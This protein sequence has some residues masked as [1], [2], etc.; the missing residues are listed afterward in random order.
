MEKQMDNQRSDCARQ[1]PL[2][3][4]DD[5]NMLE[6]LYILVRNKW[7]II[8]ATLLGIALGFGTAMMKGP[9]W[10]AEVIIAPKETE[11]PKAPNFSAFGALGGIVA[12]QLNMGANASLDKIELILDSREFNATFVERANLTPDIYKLQWPKVFRKYWDSGRHAWKPEFTPPRFLEMGSMVKGTY[13]NKEIYKNNTMILKIH[14]KDSAFSV[15]FA[16]AYIRFLDEYIKSD[17]QN[18]AKENVGYLERQLNGI[19]DPLLREKIQALIANEIEKQ[20]LV[21]KEA[22]K[23]VDPVFL[24]NHFKAKRVFP[25]I[26]GI[27]LF[28]LSCIFFIFRHAYSMSEKTEEDKILI[29]KLKR[30]IGI[31]PKNGKR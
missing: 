26:L 6:Y 28:I 12:S 3:D 5:V 20:M 19:A 11:S 15:N 18:E 17:V 1:S 16:N 30:E 7:W 14:S 22:F 27:G 29:E 31:L 23:I 21:S 10:I 24:S 2:R 4:P 13:L 8:A 9:Q 25:S